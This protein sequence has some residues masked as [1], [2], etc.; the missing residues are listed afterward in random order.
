MAGQAVRGNNQCVSETSQVAPAYAGIGAHETPTPVLELMRTVACALARAGWT[1]RS[2]MSPGADRAFYEG[3]LAGDGAVELYLPWPGFGAAARRA[4]EERKA[5]VREC[6][7]PSASAYE[8][9]GR[10][11]RGF[12]E[13]DGRRRALLAR[14]GHQVL[15]GELSEPARLVLCWTADGGCDGLSG[16]AGGTGQALR[17]AHA[18]GIEVL[19]LARTE[20][21]AR[22]HSC[23]GLRR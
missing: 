17:I 7:R 8:L 3:A 10:F 5:R 23:A 20:H 13:F 1:L 12:G 11:C 21:A 2:G 22:A 4:G 6:G 9:A 18:L 19:N 14:D 15:G 16:R